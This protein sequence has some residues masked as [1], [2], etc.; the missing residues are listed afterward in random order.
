MT[1]AIIFDFD[2]VIADSF[3]V[4]VKFIRTIEPKFKDS[5]L[6]EIFK[7]NYW[8]NAP[9]NLTSKNM[10][11][12]LENAYAK[13]IVNVKINPKIK[14]L[15]VSLNKKYELFII[16]SNSV[17]AINPFLEKNKIKSLFKKILG[18]EDS[19]SKEIKF[20]KILSKFNLKVNDCIFVT[21][22]SG[23][24]LELKKVGIKTIAVSWGFHKKET[25]KKAKPFAI[26][27]SPRELLNYL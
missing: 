5:S 22:T 25:L 16:T 4:V 21:D 1:K 19:L 10:I 6:R 15:L 20:N 12:K 3:E 27:S 8:E 23:D 24:I 18:R 2:G 26:I 13:D 17:N 9:K 7:G 11:L 14:E